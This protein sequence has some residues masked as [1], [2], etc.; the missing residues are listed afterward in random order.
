[1]VS[2]LYA[3]DSSHDLADSQREK[4]DRLQKETRTNPVIRVREIS[5]ADTGMMADFFGRGLG[6]RAEAYRNIFEILRNHKT[7][8][9]FPK[10]GY[11]AEA[12]G[13]VVGGIILI[14]SSLGPDERRA[15]RC[16]VTAWYF[17]PEFRGYAV[18]F[19]SRALNRNEVTYLNLSARAKAAAIIEAQGFKKYSHGQFIAV[20]ALKMRKGHARIAGI[21]AIPE[22]LCE[23]HERDLLLDH[24]K[25]GCICMWCLTADRAYPFVFQPRVIKRIIPGVRLIYCREIGDLVRFASPIGVYLAARGKLVISVD[26]NAPIEGLPGKYFDGVQ[27]RWYKGARPRLGDLAYT[28]PALFPPY[29]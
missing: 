27:P 8:P 2:D 5:D 23:P 24:E 7:P 10:Y 1:M 3:A 22:I 9:R 6:Y 20:P 21:D 14:Y 28:L 18:L 29:G 17:E 25:Q 16:H 4:D 19:T 11:L 15:I 26:A 12:D 13:S